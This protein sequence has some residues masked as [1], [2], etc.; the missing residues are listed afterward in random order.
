MSILEQDFLKD[1]LYSMVHNQVQQN[2]GHLKQAEDQLNSATRSYERYK[3]KLTYWEEQLK[4]ISTRLRLEHD[5]RH[6]ES[7]F[8]ETMQMDGSL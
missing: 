2:R 1:Q 5:N 4:I 3:T 6:I 8:N 7:K